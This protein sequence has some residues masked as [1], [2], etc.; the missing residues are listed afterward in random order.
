MD[1]INELEAERDAL[2]AELAA[3]KA[4]TEQQPSTTRQVLDLILEECRYWQ[5]R[6][7]ARRGSFACLYAK[8]KEIADN[9]APIA[10]TPA[11]GTNYKLKFEIL[12]EHAKR[13]DRVIA[14]M[15]YDENIRR[16]YDTGE[17]WFWA[18]DGTDNL[19]TLACPVVINA[20]DLR[21]LID[22]RSADGLVEALEKIVGIELK[23]FGADWEE[24]EEAQT[25]ACEALAAHRAGGAS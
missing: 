9:A 18:G 15:R 13:Q 16:Y 5:G 21:A 24:I 17:V 11:D 22:G 4:Q 14:D 3:L 19:D 23:D 6:D 7:E 10:Q 2:R 12:V 20:G 8:A 25:I 1:R